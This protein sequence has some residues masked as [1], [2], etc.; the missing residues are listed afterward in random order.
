MTSVNPEADLESADLLYPDLAT[1]NF[2]IYHSAN[3]KWYF[4]A[5]QDVTEAIVFL[6]ADNGPNGRPGVPHCSLFNPFVP[7]GECPRESIEVRL[8]AC[9]EK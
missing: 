1:E 8:L 5:P 7:E 3:H 4:I 6:Q 9:Y 2:Q